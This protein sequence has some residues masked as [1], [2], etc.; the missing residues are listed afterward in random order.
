MNE[1]KNLLRRTY[2]WTL[3]LAERK[4]SALWLGLLSFAEASFFPIPPDVLV[5]I[6]VLEKPS[7]WF[8]IA[9]VAAIGSTLG[10]M[11]GY[12]IEN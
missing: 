11:F 5:I 2:D 4:L 12:A 7:L 9:L 6:L 10:G 1:R 3:S 8:I